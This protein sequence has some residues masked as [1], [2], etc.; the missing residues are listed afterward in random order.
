[1]PKI[2]PAALPV[3][4][5]TAYPEPYAEAVRGRARVRLGD[6][7]GLTQYG[8]NL[9]TL[10]PGVASSHRHWHAQE[11]EFVFVLTG[12][13]TL[14]EDDGSHTRT[15]ALRAGEAAGFPAGRAVGHR[16]INRS[17]LEATYL[18]IGTRAADEV[19]TYT[20]EAV[21][22]QAVKEAGG[23]WVIRRKDGTPY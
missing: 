21:D 12:E 8:V 10:P 4:T 13:L 7:A 20:D 3:S 9:V 22:M 6:A 2:D 15:W 19:S 1:M 11:D 18:E 14:E 5:G 23:D 17:G 16:L